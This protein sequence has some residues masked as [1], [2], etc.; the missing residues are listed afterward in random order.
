LNKKFLIQLKAAF[1][2]VV[3]SLNTISGFA[4]AM[5]IN[6]GFDSGQQP[7]SSARPHKSHPGNQTAASSSLSEQA[8]GAG[9]MYGEKSCHATRGQSRNEVNNHGN[10]AGDNSRN[11]CGDKMIQFDKLDKSV[12]KYLIIV[13]PVFP[14][15]FVSAFF[16][17]KGLF[18][19]RATTNIK[20][21]VRSY[22][23]PIP[24]IRVRIRSF[25]V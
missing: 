2:L 12:V 20:Y 11:C 25:Q 5:G 4:C 16:D 10:S 6:M 1:L 3:F 19:S 23:L 7:R 15:V 14:D 22:H 18:D 13:N 8:N 9:Q 24:D 17:V 21:F